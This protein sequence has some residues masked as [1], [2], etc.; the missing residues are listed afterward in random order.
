MRLFELLR[1]PYPSAESP[2]RELRQAAIIG[3]FVGLFLLVFQPFGLSMWQTP[4]KPLKILGFGLVTFVITAYNFTVWPKLFPRQFVDER[5]NIGRQ[6]MLITGNILLIAIGNRLYLEWMLD[7]EGYTDYIS[8]LEMILVTFLLGLFPTT[9]AVMFNYIR[10]LKMYS[11][12]A[13]GFPMYPPTPAGPTNG[14]ETV[15]LSPPVQ[16]ETPLTLIS[17]NERDIVT[18]DAA[19]LLYIESSDNYCTVVYQ[20]ENQLVKPLLRSSLSRMEGQINLPRIVRCHRSY[21]V[22]LDR[23]E[24]VT[25][26]AQGYRLHLANGMLQIPV[27]RQYNATLVAELKAL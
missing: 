4:D 7:Q 6:I 8:W 5:W 9:G 21:V 14:T 3:L 25:G 17:D 16:V 24:R 26:N 15:S 22:N 11:Q 27:S 20:K 12:S 19:Q 10:K 2:V 18:L 23:V 13:A 1:Q